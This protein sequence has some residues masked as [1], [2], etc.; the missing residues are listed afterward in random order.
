MEQTRKPRN[1]PTYIESTYLQKISH[2]CTM[3]KGQTVSS[4]N[5]VGK[6]GQPHAKEWNWTSISYHTQKLTQNRL[7]IWMLRPEIIKLLEE[8]IGGKLFDVGLGDYF[9]LSWHWKQKQK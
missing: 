1:K 2:E 5:G 6:T 4:I 8:N 3:E 9:F 7:K